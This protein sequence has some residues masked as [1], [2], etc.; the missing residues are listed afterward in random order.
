MRNAIPNIVKSRN[1]IRNLARTTLT[2]TSFRR[3]HRKER[4]LRSS[5]PMFAVR[6][7]ILLAWCMAVPL[8]GPS[9]HAKKFTI[10]TEP[11]VDGRV[12]LDGRFVGVAPV[13]VDIKP[14]RKDP[15]TITVEKEG[16]MMEKAALVTPTQPNRIVIRLVS[17][18]KKYQVVTQPVAEGRVFIDGEF[19][20]IAPIEVTLSLTKTEPTVITAEKTESISQWPRTVQPSLADTDTRILVRLEE[21]T[22]FKE[23]EESDMCNKWVTVT[24]RRALN[25]TDRTWQKLVSLITDSFPD[26]QQV[27]RTSYYLRSA[28][29]VREYAFSVLRHR[30]VIKRGVGDDF[31]LRLMLESQ[32]ASSSAEGYREEQFKESKRIF[33]AD[34]ETI[35]FIR[36]QL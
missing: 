24:P 22:A 5:L 27:D 31:T 36:D 12:L 17:T 26:L 8:I 33:P 18:S 3:H 7:G 29:R 20:G 19:A 30:L 32:I 11:V 35:M 23:T 16:A 6:L 10:L 28:W 4:R 13:T 2:I 21:D 9:A 25:D 15:V 1:L 34:N 14:R